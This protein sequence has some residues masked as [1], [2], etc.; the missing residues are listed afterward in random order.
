MSCRIASLDAV[1]ILDSRGNPTLRVRVELDDGRRV[2]A[3]VPS[4]AS[5]GKHEARELRDGDPSRYRGKGVLRAVESVAQTVAPELVGF[6]PTL[7]SDIDRCLI[8]LDGTKEKSRLGANV[9]VGVSMAVA[10]A[11]AKATGMPLYRYLSRKHVYRL[12]VPMMNVIN[13]GA[14][15]D[16]SLDFQE[17]MLVPHGAP[18]FAEAVRYGVE[19][20]QALKTLLGKLGYDTSVGDEG[21]FAPKLRDNEEPCSLMVEAIGLAGFVPGQQVAIA[22]D[23]AASGFRASDAYLLR[24]SGIGHKTS[25]ELIALYTRWLDRYPIVSIE[26][27]LGE[28]DWNGFRALTATLG[29]RT[30]IVGD[31]LYVTNTSF[32]ERGV[33]ERATNAALIKLNQIGTVTETIDAIEMCRAAG[34]EFIISHRSGETEDAF[35]ADFAVAMG[36]AQIKTGSLCRSERIAKYNRLLEIEQEL[37]DDAEFR[38]PFLRQLWQKRSDSQSKPQF[39]GVPR[40]LDPERHM[41]DKDLQPGQPTL[42]EM[43]ADPLVWTVMNADG[44]D[45]QELRSLLTRAAEDLATGSD[46]TSGAHAVTDLSGAY[47]RGVGIMLLNKQNEVLVGQRANT[48][49]DAWQMPQGGIDEDEEPRNA[50][51]RELREEIGTDR[52]DILAES[53]AWLRY[54]LPPELRNRWHG[55]WRGQQQKWFVMRFLGNDADINI[56]TAQP[57]FSAWKWIAIERLPD[58]VVSFK[59]QLYR[60][61]LAEVLGSEAIALDSAGR[62]VRPKPDSTS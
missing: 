7:Q 29:D 40:V 21:G 35:I 41:R 54:D 59:R 43:L 9:I 52:A 38:S 33:A 30:Q 45:E 60:D 18:T 27:G 25:S 55:R 37:G 32:I 58:L 20:F 15:A 47:R 14:H 4:G 53:H 3:S 22:L 34:W 61:L 48:P 49:G 11:G 5:T 44:V 10:R 56:A 42:E 23:P 8:E 2:A 16:N 57:E 39:R 1:E 12:P 51:L 28:D 36:A 19:T 31:D 24:K 62:K 50:A 46:R 13:G 26:D 6:D 17:F